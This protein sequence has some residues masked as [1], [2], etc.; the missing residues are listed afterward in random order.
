MTNKNIT[1]SLV[2]T[3]LF[4]AVALVLVPMPAKAAYTCSADSDCGSNGFV[5]EQFCQ[6]NSLY[7]NFVSYTCNNPGSNYSS[8]TSNKYPQLV[9][10]CGSQVCKA[11]I[12]FIGC[13]S[14][15]ETNG[16]NYNSGSGSNYY[17]TPYNSNPYGYNGSSDYLRCEGNTVFWYD[18]YGNK[19]S[20]YQECSAYNQT[21]QNN[22][23]VAKT[24]VSHA[25]RGC[26]NG[27]AYWYDS[28]GTQQEVYQTCGGINN[29]QNGQCVDGTAT[30]TPA[31]A[32]KPQISYITVKQN[33][34]LGLTIFAK[35]TG[36][37]N[38]TKE[39]TVAPGE[40]I[41]FV[42]I[43]KNTSN[44]ALP[45]VNIKADL[46]NNISYLAN[47]KINS[48]DSTENI[49]NGINVDSL[50]KGA[51][52]MINFD[53]VAI[54][55]QSQTGIKITGTVSSGSIADSDNATIHVEGSKVT[56][57]P[58]QSNATAALNNNSLSAFFQKWYM[59]GIILL[60]LIVLFVIIFRRLSSNI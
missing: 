34:N 11:G 52:M 6:G 27:T 48:A 4:L 22:A 15:N 38:I 37:E 58:A 39:L 55:P 57:A 31:P 41:N 8:C 10:N 24:C 7:G 53:G 54:S 42:V 30:T 20:V 35:K 43:V 49:L 44:K 36:D 1:L 50:E 3:L 25:T 51:S 14:P 59:W 40:T 60:V 9:R 23:C 28:C 56:A 33:E 46:T 16:Y 18:S 5:G 12:W 19:K 21:C 13:Q 47:L 26:V 17:G 32:P 2:V 45:K 29:C